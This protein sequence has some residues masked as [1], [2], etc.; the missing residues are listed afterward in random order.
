MEFASK[1]P[2]VERGPAGSGVFGA[3]ISTAPERLGG[4]VLGNIGR[5]PFLMIFSQDRD[6]GCSA[7]I[8]PGPLPGVRFPLGDS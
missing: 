6:S 1:I 8:L 4:A 5:E 7:P 3:T 2:V